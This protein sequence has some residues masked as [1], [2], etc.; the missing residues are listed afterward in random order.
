MGINEDGPWARK[1]DG[2]Q[3]TQVVLGYS[4]G[5]DFWVV[6]ARPYAAASSDRRSARDKASLC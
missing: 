4:V 6:A 3:A 2:E 5:T 1:E